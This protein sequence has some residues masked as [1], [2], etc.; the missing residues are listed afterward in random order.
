MIGQTIS[1]YR[2][3]EKLGGGGMGV[4]YEAE[5]LKLVRHVALRFLHEEL[6]D[7]PA[8]VIL[9]AILNRAPVAPVRLNPDLPPELEE[10]ITYGKAKTSSELPEFGRRISGANSGPS[11]VDQ[12]PP[13]TPAG[14]ATYCLPFAR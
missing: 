4:V 13:P 14:M 2:I 10:I 11:K 9:E 8:A 6:K 5:D 3:L 1:H 7:D 12:L